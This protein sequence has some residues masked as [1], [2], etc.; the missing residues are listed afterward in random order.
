MSNPFRLPRFPASARPAAARA[1]VQAIAP[2]SQSVPRLADFRLGDRT[3]LISPAV[4]TGALRAFEFLML[5][6]TGLLIA[7]AYVPETDAFG[8]RQYLFALAGAGTLAVLL[9]EAMGHYKLAA[10]SSPMIRLPRVVLAWAGSLALLATSVFFLK[11]GPEFSRVWLAL[12]FAIGAAGLIIVRVMLAVA[13]RRWARQGRLNRRAVVFGS[14]A[15]V[16]E[17]IA[18]LEGDPT[19]DIRICGVFND[20]PEAAAPG[21]ISGYPVLGTLAELVRIG[22]S[23]RVDMIILAMPM[24]D[25][26][27]LMQV[28]KALWV[29][30]VDIRL[31]G[32]ATKLKLCQRAYSYVGKVPLID[33]A[34]KPIADWGLVAKAAFD[35]LVGVTAL[36]LLAPV[37]AAIALAIRLDSRGPVLF[38]QRRYGFNNELIEIYKFR[39]MYVDQSDANATRLVTK[40]DPRVTRVGR[41]IRKASLDE[42]PQ[43]FNVLKGDLSLVGPR[44]HA[45]EAKAANQRYDE[46]VE[47]YFAR[48][49]VKP[50]IT[51]WAQINGWRG[52]T[53]TAEKIQKR[54]E[55]DLYYIE[56]WS[57]LLD[58]YILAA[59]PASLLKTDQAY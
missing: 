42:L 44:P 6:V 46:V 51:G 1:K 56:N 52:E 10:L 59:T 35:K 29:L 16:K 17:L 43:L 25:E 20:N 19:T 11:V 55:H 45:L 40:G 41:F 48:H 13:V 8:S 39:S 15:E 21:L 22:R 3:S 50:G 9:I 12:W 14:S 2:V 57:L 33:I 47:S 36:V 4:V 53:D 58:V 49:K 18:R 30:P 31:A 5:T 7:A 23:T 24:S 32:T 37:M 26:A 38:R 34:D 27:R 28:L 54:V